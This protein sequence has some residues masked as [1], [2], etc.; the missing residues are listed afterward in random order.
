[1]SWSLRTYRA[2]TTFLLAGGATGQAIRAIF[3]LTSGEKWS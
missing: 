3:L 1:M 2:A